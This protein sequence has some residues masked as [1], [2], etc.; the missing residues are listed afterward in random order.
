LR[1]HRLNSDVAETSIND[2][3]AIAAAT[4]IRANHIKGTLSLPI[5]TLHGPFIPVDHLML[6]SIHPHL[7]CDLA[8]S[9]PA[10]NFLHVGRQLIDRK[11]PARSGMAVAVA[12]RRRP[13]DAWRPGRTQVD[14][15]C[16][17]SPAIGQPCD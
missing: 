13:L 11:T 10:A 3:T 1:P 4:L 2:V 8:D 17:P 7:S 16:F 14:A 15:A 12:S 6:D 5:S 9:T